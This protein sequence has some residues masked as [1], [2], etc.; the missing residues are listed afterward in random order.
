MNTML[1]YAQKEV[2]RLKHK[3]NDKEGAVIELILDFSR[4][5][6]EV[7][8]LTG[9]KYFEE[10]LA[11]LPLPHTQESI[12]KACELSHFDY[13]YFSSDFAEDTENISMQI[14]CTKEQARILK[15]RQ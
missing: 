12:K 10:Q 11:L 2:Q 9:Y 15:Y 7:T 6:D 1:R 4:S 14:H 5:E 13:Y 3:Q 8:R